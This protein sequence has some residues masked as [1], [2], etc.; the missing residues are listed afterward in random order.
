MVKR[1]RCLYN[2]EI[3]GIESIY[4][5]ING[6]QIN[7]PGKVEALRRLGREGL[8]TCPCGCGSKL[9][10][11]AGDKNLREQHFRIK[12]GTGSTNCMITQEETEESIQS[13]IALKCWLDDKLLSDRTLCQ[14]S[15]RELG[16]SDRKFEFT[17]YEPDL[18]IGISYWH[19]RGNIED[20]K[21]RY[22]AASSAV[23]V[24]YVAGN[25]NEDY[26]GQYPEFVIKVQNIQHYV[27]YIRLG[28]GE[29]MPYEE[30]KMSAIRYGKNLDGEWECTS[31]AE[32]LL[33]EFEIRQDGRIFFHGREL[34]DCAKEA[35]TAFETRQ[36]TLRKIR[37][38]EKELRERE[39]RE[40]RERLAREERERQE[41]LAGE[42]R[43]RREAEEKERK[44]YEAR[45]KLAVENLLKRQEEEKQRYQ[46]R[47]K[48]GL[49]E[50]QKQREIEKEMLRLTIH[51]LLDQQEVPARD[52]RG[53]RWVRCEFCHKEDM[54]SEFASYGGRGRIN[55]GICKK[56][57]S[58]GKT[59]Q[60]IQPVFRQKQNQKN[61]EVTV[62]P[63]CNGRLIRRK[64]RYGDFYGCSNYPRCRYTRPGS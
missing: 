23:R 6:K 37:E 41:R 63:L 51:E 15:L 14:V 7:I 59:Y 30:A 33:K 17:I 3:I 60:V 31:L 42:E 50:E 53:N 36:E 24:I 61:E 58:E 62:C 21:L 40:R 22:L 45:R 28:S 38:K 49:L 18:K 34:T 56:C 64:G 12:N 20:E 4:T 11:V 52:S 9:I 35:K 26:M 5:A 19:L 13:K 55:I 39:E 43:K 48:E 57:S 47:Q 46:E 54:D 32:G 25:V 16:E 8:L 29:N 1:S 10:L 2:G 27:L 44:E